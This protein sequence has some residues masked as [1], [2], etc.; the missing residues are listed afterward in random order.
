MQKILSTLLTIIF[1]QT[2]IFAFPVSFPIAL[3]NYNSTLEMAKSSG[4][5]QTYKTALKAIKEI[6]N[7]I[8]ETYTATTNA[9]NVENLKQIGYS[10]GDRAYDYKENPMLF[11]KDSARIITSYDMY[12]AGFNNDNMF[13]GSALVLGGL[14]LDIAGAPIKAGKGIVKTA[15][16]LK[17]S[18]KEI[19]S[20]RQLMN[21][22]EIVNYNKYWDNVKIE[23]IEYNKNLRNLYSSY[24]PNNG[25]YNLMDSQ[26]LKIGTL[27]DRYGHTSGTYFAPEGTPFSMRSLP[28]FAREKEYHVYKVIKEFTPETGLT[29]SWF[30]QN[31]GGI[32]YRFIKD[33]KALS[34]KDM[35]GEYIIEIDKIK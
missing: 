17:S 10:I 15:K 28:S 25:L 9:S 24:P 8:K 13:Y 5:K 16:V 30:N 31:G 29:A 11:V 3:N 21:G 19:A 2:S 12:E 35:L 32:Q 23:R 33:N 22:D 27:I 26:P 7:N 4:D 1:F 20:L 6:P 18:E 34:I 14:A